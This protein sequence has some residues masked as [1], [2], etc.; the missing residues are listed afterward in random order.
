[1][2]LITI[3]INVYS[4]SFRASRRRYLGEIGELANRL[5]VS[6]R[7]HNYFQRTGAHLFFDDFV[8][9]TLQTVVLLS[10]RMSKELDQLAS[11]NTIEV[12]VKKLFE[13][14]QSYSRS[15]LLLYILRV[16]LLY[17][18]RAFPDLEESFGVELWMQFPR[19]L[20]ACQDLVLRFQRSVCRLV[21]PSENSYLVYHA[22]KCSFHNLLPPSFVVQG[23]SSMTCE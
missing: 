17:P 19:G 11:T 1:M 7:S 20:P 13:T 14:L 2:F 4:L 21:P 8:A 18:I 5:K 9:G 23:L 22:S 16:D 6:A 10:C 12:R 15:M 3:L